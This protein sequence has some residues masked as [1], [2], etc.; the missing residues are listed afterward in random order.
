MPD[1]R[2]SPDANQIPDDIWLDI[3]I[4]YLQ[5]QDIVSLSEVNNRLSRLFK[6]QHT[7]SEQLNRKKTLGIL[8]VFAG[9]SSTFLF[10][11]LNGK[12]RLFKTRNS[13][14]V[15]SDNINP[16]LMP[17]SLPENISFIESIQ[18]TSNH[19]VLVGRDS[20][21]HIIVA[22]NKINQDYAGQETSHN[23]VISLPLH[24][25]NI[26]LVS[27]G[28]EENYIL[29]PIFLFSRNTRGQLSLA[30]YKINDRTPLGT[31][32]GE[33]NHPLPIIPLP[34]TMKTVKQIHS[35]IWHTVIRGYDQYNRP[36]I[37]TFGKNYDGQLGTGDWE[38]R[39]TPTLIKL[40]PEMFTLHVIETSFFHTIAIG[41][42]KN[43]FPIVASCGYNSDGQLGCGDKDNKNT[44]ISIKLPENMKSV[45]MVATGV[46]HTVIVGKDINNKPVVA[47]CGHNG[48]G[49]LGTGDEQDRVCLTPIPIPKDLITIDYVEA[50]AYHTV[51]CGRNIKNQPIIALCGC[52][53]NGELG[54]APQKIAKKSSLMTNPAL[55]F[56]PRPDKGTI[57]NLM[58]ISKF[59]PCNLL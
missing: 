4:N 30:S 19:T 42:D 55:F 15:D 16:I 22:T 14:V 37:A 38:N 2:G 13:S 28:N 8:K 40:P 10:A 3:L 35:G 27:A 34:Y 46:K 7:Q 23:Q 50:G 47:T 51:I 21:D 52:N 56:P 43:G 41:L 53:S 58:K 5:P 6:T 54:F 26:S 9:Y 48:Y 33:R 24:D 1:V 44:L 32:I 36:Q 31:T 12:Q 45:E 17:I 59:S 11:R 25:N 57:N 39:D 49:Q 29:N 18:S 20:H